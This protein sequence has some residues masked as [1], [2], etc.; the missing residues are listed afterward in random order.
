LPPA[1][2]GDQRAGGEEHAIQGHG[3]TEVF[4]VSGEDRERETSRERPGWVHPPD[5]IGDGTEHAEK[6][7]ELEGSIV[8]SPSDNQPEEDRR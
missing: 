8:I 2:E 6:R 7:H 3:H 4:P 1:E 5:E